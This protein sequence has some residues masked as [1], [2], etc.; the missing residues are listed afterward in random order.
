[1]G[2]SVTK[3]GKMLTGILHSSDGFGILAVMG[4]LVA[5]LGRCNMGDLNMNSS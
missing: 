3:D 1:M 5:F 2:S 4:V